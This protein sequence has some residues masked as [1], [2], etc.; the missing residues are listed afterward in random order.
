MASC[1]GFVLAAYQRGSMYFPLGADSVFAVKPFECPWNRPLSH[2]LTM[3][4]SPATLG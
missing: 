1:L 2:S 3:S 4:E